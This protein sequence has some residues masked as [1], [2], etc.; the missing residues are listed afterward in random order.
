MLAE[1][2]IIR[3]KYS[4]SSIQRN[5]SCVYDVTNKFFLNLVKKMSTLVPHNSTTTTQ[6]CHIEN[7]NHLSCLTF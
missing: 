7:N 2:S 6:V 5:P 4:C 3:P 1:C